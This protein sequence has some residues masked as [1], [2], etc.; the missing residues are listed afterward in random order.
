MISCD[1]VS[2]SAV[3][4]SLKNILR[5]NTPALVCTYFPAVAREM[6]ERSYPVMAPKSRSTM[7][8]IAERSLVRKKAL[9]SCAIAVMTESSVVARCVIILI[10]AEASSR[11]RRTKVYASRSRCEAPGAGGSDAAKEA[12]IANSGVRLRR[13][14]VICP[15]AST[16]TL[17]SGTM[18]RI[19]SADE[20]LS[21]RLPGLGFRLR[22]TL[23]AFCSSSSSMRSAARSRE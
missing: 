1:E 13:A 19:R 15:S 12:S 21:K 6:V 8:R 16:S 18:W 20:A 22:I 14:T 11:L 10:N 2:A 9:C 23:R 7:G 4:A 3:G 5:G 17:K